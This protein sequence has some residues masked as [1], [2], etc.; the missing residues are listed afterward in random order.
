[1]PIGTVPETESQA[2]PLTKL[3]PEQQAEAWR[4]A[5]D[6]AGG[7]PTAK[8]V[9]AAVIE[10]IDAEVVSV[11]KVAAKKPEDA[12]AIPYRI[13]YELQQIEALAS[14]DTARGQ[15]LDNLIDWCNREKLKCPKGIDQKAAAGQ[16]AQPA[17]DC[18]SLIAK[19]NRNRQEAFSIVI[20]WI[21]SQR[22]RK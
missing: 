17:I 15:A 21:E 12:K 20:A 19:S 2:R 3:P 4:K 18:L 6:A 1:M 11:P 22:K 13:R 5:C 7:Q 8:Q 10:I 16:L 14:K 9:E